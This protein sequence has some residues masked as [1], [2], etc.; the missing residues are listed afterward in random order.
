[1]TEKDLEEGRVYP[2]LS[3]I[4]SVSLKIATDIATFAYKNS[5][6]LHIPEPENLEKFIRSLRYSTDYESYVPDIYE[7]PENA[8]Q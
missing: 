2:P 5:L 4:Q 3:S 1:M 8:K 6:A 7:W